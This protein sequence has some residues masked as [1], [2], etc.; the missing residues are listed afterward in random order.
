M[1]LSLSPADIRRD[2]ILRY[3][4][5]GG[6]TL[7]ADIK[8]LLDEC[9]E[10]CIAAAAPRYVA[11]IFPAKQETD[12]IYLEG[13]TL[14]LTGADIFS[15][16]TGAPAVAVMA[17]TLG[18][19]VDRAIDIANRQDMTR[20]LV[21]D[22][23]ASATIEAVCDKAEAAIKQEIQGRFPYSNFRYSPGYGDLPLSLQPSL[24]TLLNAERSIGL[25]CSPSLILLPRKSVTA[26]FGLFEQLPSEAGLSSKDACL[27]CRAYDNC[28]LRKAG[29]P[30][31]HPNTE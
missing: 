14:H 4:G 5:Y 25:T 24:I 23:T 15:H 20:A 3:L 10:Q 6:Q 31:G 13:S 21:L 27:G 29:S 7:T 22:A 17:A 16:L 2:E 28:I 19:G 18:T 9:I 8:R 30:C 12:S 1:N 11:R 26:V